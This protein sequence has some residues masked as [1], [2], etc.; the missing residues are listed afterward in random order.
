[1][2]F[3]VDFLGVAFPLPL[4]PAC[5]SILVGFGVSG[6]R[7]SFGV[8]ASGVTGLALVLLLVLGDRECCL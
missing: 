2:K 6:D 1:M 4:G 3:V 7:G 8:C 5:P